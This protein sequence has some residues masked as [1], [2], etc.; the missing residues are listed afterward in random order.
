MLYKK[1]KIIA[2]NSNKILAQELEKQMEIELTKVDIDKFP[3]GEKRIRIKEDLSDDLVFVLQSLVEPVDEMLMEL[4]LLVDACRNSGA[5]RIVAVIPWL[6]YSA[7]DKIFRPGEPLS[8][9]LVAKLIK[10]AGVQEVILLETHSPLNQKYFQEIGLE[11]KVLNAVD[12][13][14]DLLAQKIKKQRREWSVLCIDKGALERSK[15]LAEKL[16]LQ[17]IKLKKDRDLNTGKVTFADFTDDLDGKKVISFD[18]FVSTGFSLIKSC[19]II[20]NLGVR[21]YLICIAHG[22]LVNRAWE[23]IQRSRIDKIWL[24]NS[25]PIPE[26]KRIAKFR[27]IS[28]AGLI[29]QTIKNVIKKK[30]QKG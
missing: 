1:T 23:K 2:G 24:S 25:Y 27:I 26:K 28:C 29:A 3:N 7:Q 17:L 22:V 5:K 20:K 19:E 11:V 12:I 6:G 9:R 15:T 18:D 4:L 30:N 13:F 8:A 21:Y 10:S 14:V 16:G